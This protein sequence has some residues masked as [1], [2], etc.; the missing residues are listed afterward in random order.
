MEKN[1]CMTEK[2][3]ERMKAEQGK[4]WEDFGLGVGT[5]APVVCPKCGAT[6]SFTRKI[7][8]KVQIAKGSRQSRTAKATWRLCLKC[9][10]NFDGRSALGTLPHY[11]IAAGAGGG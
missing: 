3:Y 2:D 10:C 4:S 1:K 6:E 11:V 5:R 9:G 8:T 7:Q